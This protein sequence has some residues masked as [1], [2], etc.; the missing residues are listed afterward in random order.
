M[1]KEYPYGEKLYLNGAY[2]EQLFLTP[3]K[4]PTT[5]R[6]YADKIVIKDK[7]LKITVKWPLLKQMDKIVFIMNGEELAFK[8]ERAKSK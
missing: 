6:I 2:T 1:T 8:R 3:P 4:G 5:L 7:E